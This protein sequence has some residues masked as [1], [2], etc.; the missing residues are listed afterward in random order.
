MQTRIVAALA[1]ALLTVAV[2]A[3]TYPARPIRIV[4]PFPPGN[5]S[6]L[7]SRTIAEPLAKR[8]GQPVV[9]DNRPG[10]AGTIGADHVAKSAPDGYTLLG[11]SSAFSVTPAVSAKLPY[12]AEKDLVPLAPIG[13]TVM[14]MV[15]ANDFPAKNVQ[16]LV[17]LL[18]KNPGKYHYAHLGSGA[19]SHMV[20]ELFKQRT[21][22][23]IIGVPYKGSGQALGDLM[24]GQLPL[25]FD[26]LTSA[27]PLAKAG[28]LRALGVSS[29]G[30]VRA[31][32]DVPPLAESGVEGL[33]DYDVVA[34]TGTF[35][36]A[37]TP[38]AIVDRLHSEIAQIMQTPETANRLIAQNLEP[39]AP[40]TQPQ[41][42]AYM[43]DEFAKWRQVARD[44]KITSQ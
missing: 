20:M 43:R 26:G 9:I 40:M 15:T 32:P 24:G 22:V 27:N 12:D 25:M 5:A 34:W 19:L 28:R 3:Q 41:W 1:G 7:A 30:R 2:H 38:K 8:L 4:V 33:K 16:E 6:D 23:D 18:R 11:T 14:L 42:A 31:A 17:A 21:G 44:G 29:K 13:W 39:F 37:G 36:P 35:A 10:A